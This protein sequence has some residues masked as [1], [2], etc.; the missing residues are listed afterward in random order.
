MPYHRIVNNQL[1]MKI[2]L[3]EISSIDEYL[4]F[5]KNLLDDDLYWFRGQSNAEHQLTP[6]LFR[7]TADISIDEPYYKRELYVIQNQDYGI[8][9]FKAALQ[10]HRDCSGYKEIDYLYLMQHFEIP[11]RLLDFTTNPLIALYFCVSF[12]DNKIETTEIE[13]ADFRENSSYS[14]KGGAIFCVKPHVINYELNLDGDKI[15][16]L[17]E[18]SFETLKNINFPVC[19]YGNNIDK[20]M[21]AQQG[22]FIYYGNMIKPLDWY[23]IM[24]PH[25]VKIFIPNSLKSKFKN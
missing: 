3:L 13:I 25:I 24:E 19:I 10:Q 2:K 4:S 17:N 5:A 23:E 18:Y 9:E 20:R 12:S 11:T 21:E 6:S 8:R 22:V 15:I 14:N 16:D 7:K 1:I